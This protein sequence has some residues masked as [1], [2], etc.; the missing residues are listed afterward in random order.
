[1]LYESRVYGTVPGRLPA[2][3]ARFARPHRTVRPFLER[4][5]RNGAKP[6]IHP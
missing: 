1:M 4:F 6:C 5:V 3:N 2:L